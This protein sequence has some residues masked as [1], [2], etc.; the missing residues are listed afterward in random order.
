MIQRRGN[1]GTITVTVIVS[2]NDS[3]ELVDSFQKY[4]LVALAGISLLFIYG[5]MSKVRAEHVHARPDSHA[6]IGV[7][8]DHVMDEDE[9]MLTYRYM[10]M[11]MDG[12]RTATD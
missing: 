6:P 8:S 2:N 4:T 12:N 10:K 3:G 11:R 9:I 1:I 5:A 7:M